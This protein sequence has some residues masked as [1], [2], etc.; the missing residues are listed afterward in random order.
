MSSGLPIDSQHPELLGHTSTRGCAV[1]APRGW[2]RLRAASGPVTI[3]VNH[4]TMTAETMRQVREGTFVPFTGAQPQRRRGGSPHRTASGPRPRPGTPRL[5]MPEAPQR[6][7]GCAGCRD[8]AGGAPPGRCSPH[9]VTCSRGPHLGR[10]GSP[11]NVARVPP[12][13]DARL[14]EPSSGRLQNPAR[15]EDRRSSV[16]RRRRASA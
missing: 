6:G 1:F 5:A 3:E 9:W 14:P 4:D 15:D 8:V 12:G 10:V 11:A 7:A 2:A 13:S 16:L